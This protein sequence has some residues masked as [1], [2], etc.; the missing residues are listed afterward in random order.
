[1]PDTNP[2]RVLFVTGKLAEPALR[3]VL[4]EMAPPF[5][6]DVTV[7][8]ITVAALM[9]TAWIARHLIVPAGTDLVLIPGLCEGA[10][11]TIASQIGIAVEKGPKDLREI[12]RHFGRAAV[13]K[14]YGPWDIEIV[15][16][17]NNAPR[18][19]REA[20]R[21]MAES[22]RARGAD[23]R[24]HGCTPGRAFSSLGDVVREL[25]A[26]GIRVSVDTF[27]PGEIRTAVDA[28]AE[29]VLGG[30]GPEFGGARG[31]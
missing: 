15:A 9:T 19:S 22:F 2:Q 20:V 21:H 11:D 31:G 18:L 7:L 13:A 24:Y 5:A 23:M 16:E 14:D 25:V 27:D 28:G 1:M 3:R 29:L 30:K 8:G 12:P 4:A 26:G 10:P 6:Y 17:I